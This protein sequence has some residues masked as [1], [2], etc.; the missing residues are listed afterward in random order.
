MA[1]APLSPR[2]PMYRAL[3]RSG[4]AAGAVVIL[5]TLSLGGVYGFSQPE[6]GRSYTVDPPPLEV[7]A[8][9]S[10]ANLVARGRHIIRTRGCVD[11]HAE[12]LGGGAIADDFALGSLWGTNLT[13]GEGGVGGTYSEQDWI[14]AIRHGVGPDYKP[15][16][17]M[18][19]HE[20]WV[21]SDEDMAAMIA[22][23]ES[24]PPVDRVTPPARPGPLSRALFLTGKMPLVPAKLVDHDAPRPVT[25][26][27]GPTVDYGGYLASGCIGCHGSRM[28]G[29]PVPGTPPGFGVPG[30]LTPDV[31]T[32]LGGWSYGDFE[33]A[34]RDG[35]SRDGRV[36]D[37]TMPVQ[38]TREF[39]DVEL[40]AMWKYLQSLEPLPF[41]NR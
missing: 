30:N 25:P 40:E 35:I 16:L 37:P 15:L 33:R 27:E 31:E 24:L 5:V 17:F 34:M 3:R 14:R 22:Y 38:F 26:P 10:K 12:D 28:S 11:C 8:S 39:T 19:S 29:G 23:I 18:P 7:A 1:T 2:R 41:G 32:G 36:L 6:F 20:F 21:I 9:G 4:Y 13:S